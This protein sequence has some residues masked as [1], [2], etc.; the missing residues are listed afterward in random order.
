M[1]NLVTLIDIACGRPIRAEDGGR[2]RRLQLM[3]FALLASL[4]F[5]AA[6]KRAGG[7]SGTVLTAQAR[8]RGGAIALALTFVGMLLALFAALMKLRRAANEERAD[9]ILAAD[10]H[11]LEAP[12]QGLP[13]R[14]AAGASRT[15]PRSAR[16]V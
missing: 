12:G 14:P 5:A 11:A 16:P 1:G 15:D 10:F 4:V 2:S 9:A 3:V 13:D 6:V 7:L 8:R